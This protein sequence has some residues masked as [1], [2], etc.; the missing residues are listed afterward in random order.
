VRELLKK[1]DKELSIIQ[2]KAIALI[3]TKDIN[4]MTIDDI[5]NEL[6][7]SRQTIY[8]WQ[9]EDEKF[10]RELN[11]QAEITMDIFLV[12]CY[13]VLQKIVRDEKEPTKNK[14]AAID[15]VLKIKG[16]YV[17]KQEL[18]IEQKGMSQE[19]LE[20]AR[21]MVIDLQNELLGSGT[22]T[23]EQLENISRLWG[24]NVEHIYKELKLIKLELIK[25][26]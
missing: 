24:G 5:A 14:L 3:V 22:V 17:D 4:G 26:V 12:E 16:K 6:G 8:K 23:P 9:R 1:N 18:S 10:R 21:H 15:K 13:E 20:V 19:S 25:T 7:I 11:N 2:Q